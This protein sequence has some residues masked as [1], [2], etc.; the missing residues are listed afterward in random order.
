MKPICEPALM[1]A[2]SALFVSERLAGALVHDGNLKLPIR[3]R[4]LKVLVTE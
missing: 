2:A 3:V 4:Q 1:E